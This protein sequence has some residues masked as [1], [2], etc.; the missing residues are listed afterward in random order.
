MANFP[1]TIGSS[2]VKVKNSAG[3]T[4]KTSSA[5][6]V[7]AQLVTKDLDL[8]KRELYKYIDAI[9]AEVTDA[10]RL[11]LVNVQVSYRDNLSDDLTTLDPVFTL[12]DLAKILFLR[13]TA[14]YIK[15]AIRSDS[16]GV[17][18]RMGALELYG[19]GH[20]RRI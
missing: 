19:R 16:V 2:F 6:P 17:R 8:G 13:V 12:D 20:G 4:I 11:H 1:R 14:R 9:V 3:T 10:S 18:W 5:N 7:A 15:I